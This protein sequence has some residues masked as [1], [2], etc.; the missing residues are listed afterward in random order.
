MLEPFLDSLEMIGRGDV[1][2][3]VTKIAKDALGIKFTDVGVLAKEVVALLEGIDV[4][5]VAFGILF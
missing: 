4:L 3:L 5:A 1:D 2:P